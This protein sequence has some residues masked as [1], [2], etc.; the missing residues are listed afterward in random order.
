MTRKIKKP[1]TNVK[2]KRSGQVQSL[3]NF[4]G[5]VFHFCT[6]IASDKTTDT[7]KVSP[8]QLREEKVARQREAQKAKETEEA[9]ERRRQAKK[10]LER[11]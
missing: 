9:E 1:M 2:T 5:L 7:V 11:Q 6:C 4:S 3:S 10:E 8:E